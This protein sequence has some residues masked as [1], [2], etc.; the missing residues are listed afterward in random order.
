ME[1]SKKYADLKEFEKSHN[2]TLSYLFEELEE[3]L[4]GKVI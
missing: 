1:K 4:K 2:K 3:L